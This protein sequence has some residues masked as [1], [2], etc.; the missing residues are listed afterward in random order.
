[1]ARCAWGRGNVKSQRPQAQ[2]CEAGAPRWV[3]WLGIGVALGVDG[4][5]EILCNRSSTCIGADRPLDTVDTRNT[6]TDDE[7]VMTRWGTE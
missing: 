7:K 4:G 5:D 3:E 1:M 6:A 2:S